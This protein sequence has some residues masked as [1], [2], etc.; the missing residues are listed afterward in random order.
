MHIFKS[1]D[2]ALGV[3]VAEKMREAESD[4]EERLKAAA[5]AKRK[6]IDAVRIELTGRDDGRYRD[7]EKVVAR[8]FAHALGYSTV[9]VHDD[10]F[11]I[12]GDSIMATTVASNTAMCLGIEFDAADLLMER[13]PAAVVDSLEAFGV[14]PADTAGVLSNA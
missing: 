4:L 13:T 1:F 6:E 9:D 8:C 12:G 7:A 11:T 3:V 14:L 10:F 2:V 5:E